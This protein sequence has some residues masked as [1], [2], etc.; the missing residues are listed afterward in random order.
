M[1]A[2]FIDINGMLYGMPQH[3]AT[4]VN[5]AKSECAV[6]RAEPSRSHTS[7]VQS[8]PERDYAG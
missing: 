6:T 7:D 5:R 8:T 2:K 4:R 3:S 1:Q